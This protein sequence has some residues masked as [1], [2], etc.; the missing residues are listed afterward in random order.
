MTRLDIANSALIDA[1]ILRLRIAQEEYGP[2]TIN[3]LISILADIYKIPI[4][5]DEPAGPILVLAA[6]LLLRLVNTPAPVINE[7]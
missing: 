6:D 3:A 2:L 5:P 4:D 1:W 7:E